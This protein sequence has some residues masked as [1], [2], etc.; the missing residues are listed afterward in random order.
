MRTP[1]GTKRPPFYITNSQFVAMREAICK[2]FDGQNI[3]RQSICALDGHK[4]CTKAANAA[5]RAMR[6]AWR[7]GDNR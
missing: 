6:K 1:P 4:Q 7:E 3:M 5:L 2:T